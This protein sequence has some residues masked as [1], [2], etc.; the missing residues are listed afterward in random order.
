[1]SLSNCYPMNGPSAAANVL[2]L[3][4]LRST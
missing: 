2:S 3:T 4:L 1:M